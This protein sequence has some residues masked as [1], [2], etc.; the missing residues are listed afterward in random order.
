MFSGGGATCISSP[1]EF[2][3]NLKD[4]ESERF[5]CKGCGTLVSEVVRYSTLTCL[6]HPLPEL[7]GKESSHPEPVTET[8]YKKS[9][10]PPFRKRGL[11]LCLPCKGGGTKVPE[12]L[13]KRRKVAFTLA[14]VLI[15]IGIIGIVAAMTLPSII[16]HYRKQEICTRLQKFSSTMQNAINMSTV[17]NGP[18]QYWVTPTQQDDTKDELVSAYINKYI[19]PYLTGIKKCDIKDPDCKNIGKTLFPN[20]NSQQQQSIYIFEDGSCFTMFFGGVSTSGGMI[21]II[22]DY[23]CLGRPNEYDKDQFSFVISYTSGKSARFYAGSNAT[24]N[25]EDR[26]RLL[27]LCKNH[28]AAH[29]KGGCSA[30]IEYDG[31]EIKDDYPWL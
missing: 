12:G 21:H 17:D 9:P 16:G 11:R 20:E 22:Y 29:G 19:Y 6:R 2:W 5:L 24:Y 25:V 15:T 3:V 1:L 27:E 8:Q 28:T 4:V 26:D 23:N 14:E 30:L 18:A 10:L 7:E 13:F 31:W